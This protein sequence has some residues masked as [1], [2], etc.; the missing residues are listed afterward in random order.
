MKLLELLYGV[1]YLLGGV[2]EG[3]GCILSSS[4]D[5]HAL[6]AVA[7]IGIGLTT[8]IRIVAQGME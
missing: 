1:F 5:F 8:L 6:I 4:F 3:A 2:A 7:L